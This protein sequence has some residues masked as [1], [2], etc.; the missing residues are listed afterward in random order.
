MPRALGSGR[1]R[2]DDDDR[3]RGGPRGRPIRGR[4][5]LGREGPVESKV[6]KTVSCATQQAA[7]QISAYASNP[8][9]G[10][11]N[12]SI[13]TGDPSSA[14]GLLGLSSKQTHYGLSG[15]CHAAKKHV[16]WTHRVGR[17]QPV[18][19][20]PLAGGLLRRAKERA[21]ALPDH[22]RLLGRPGER[23]DRDRA[24]EE[25]E[26]ADRVRALVAE[27]VGDVLPR[28]DVHDADAVK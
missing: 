3:S 15:A 1:A 22:A 7:L 18:G 20:R 25:A 16:A 10:A 27:A 9:I 23:V 6:Q 19:R 4:G 17:R 21:A 24:A 11:A 28:R 26:E 14:T 8:D 13:T 5:D 12:V 2:A